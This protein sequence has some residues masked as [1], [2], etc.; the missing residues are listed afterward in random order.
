MW[1]RHVH[2]QDER[3]LFV[4]SD[5]RQEVVRIFPGHQKRERKILSALIAFCMSTSH[6]SFVCHRKLDREIKLQQQLNFLPP[7]RMESSEE[8]P[9]LGSVFCNCLARWPK[10][11][12]SKEEHFRMFY[13]NGELS[14]HF[15]SMDFCFNNLRQ[16]G[17]CHT[18]T[19]IKW[20][21]FPGA[22][23]YMRTLFQLG[24]PPLITGPL[25]S[26]RF[27]DR[28]YPQLLAQL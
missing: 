16:L 24:W 22:F 28:N 14:R 1:Y 23:I 8:C 20:V 17:F 27:S 25:E 5:P 4:F 6:P 9:K 21:C 13:T 26:L 15:R 10:Y 19:P 11:S 12:K 18:D 2:E 3:K 7:S